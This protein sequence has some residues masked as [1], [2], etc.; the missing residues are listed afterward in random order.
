MGRWEAIKGRVIVRRVE[1]E[2]D[3]KSIIL[4]PDTVKEQSKIGIVVSAGSDCEILEV[5]DKILFARYSPHKLPLDRG[6]FKGFDI[7]NEE[8]VLCVYI[9]DERK[10][11]DGRSDS[12]DIRG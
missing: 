6:E 11:E 7:M 5:G 8:D 9:E 12:T 1:E 3:N 2:E 4:T 10:E